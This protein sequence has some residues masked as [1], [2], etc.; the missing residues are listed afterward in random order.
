MQGITFLFTVAFCGILVSTKRDIF[1]DSKIKLVF[2]FS[3]TVRA[4][5]VSMLRINFLSENYHEVTKLSAHHASNSSS[6]HSS[7]YSYVCF[8]IEI[9]KHAIFEMYLW[10]CIPSKVI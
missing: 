5:P 6:S 1:N 3:D 9:S 8:L 4:R 7:Y 2:I 10:L